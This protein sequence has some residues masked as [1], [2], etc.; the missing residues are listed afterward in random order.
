MGLLDKTYNDDFIGGQQCRDDVDNLRVILPSK[1]PS[2]YSQDFLM[3]FRNPKSKQGQS[4]PWDERG[5][6][7]D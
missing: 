2:G 1:E 3:G 7:P 5:W 4:Y 6:K